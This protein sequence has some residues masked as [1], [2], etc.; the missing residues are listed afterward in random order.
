M[1]LEI[2][3]LAIESHFKL[4]LILGADL[5]DTPLNCMA[6]VKE[7]LEVTFVITLKEIVGMDDR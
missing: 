1:R 6:L 2:V 4:F 7:L 3:L 5:I